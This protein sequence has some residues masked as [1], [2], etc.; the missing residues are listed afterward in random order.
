[1]Q[2]QD[3]SS[4]RCAFPYHTIS[5][6]DSE[7]IGKIVRRGM[8]MARDHGRNDIDQMTCVMDIA[9]LHCNG[10]PLDLFA[11]LL[12][13]DEDFRVDFVKIGVHIDR[14]AGI[15]QHGVRLKFA[16]EQRGT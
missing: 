8:Q 13:N 4:D 5:P 7:L 12:A 9:T 15:I 2:I 14:K 6:A 10:T 11:F 16:K 1:M 3:P